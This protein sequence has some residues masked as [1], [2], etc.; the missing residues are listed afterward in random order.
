VVILG[1]F[2]SDDQICFRWRLGDNEPYWAWFCFLYVKDQIGLCVYVRAC[3][4]VVND[5]KITERLVLV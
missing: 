4:C 3:V 1:I 2:A 5:G